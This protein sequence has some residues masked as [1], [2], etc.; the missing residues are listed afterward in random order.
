VR[1]FCSGVQLSDDPVCRGL[2]S[3]PY[4]WTNRDVVVWLSA[5][6]GL[7]LPREQARLQMLME[8]GMHGALL[9][10]NMYVAL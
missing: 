7:Q 8:S 5:V 10:P 4:L 1:F 3:D 6:L 2:P 9:F